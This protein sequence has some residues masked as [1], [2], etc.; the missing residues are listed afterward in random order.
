MA[1]LITGLDGPRTAQ[2]ELFHDLDDT[3]AIIG[4]SAAELKTIAGQPPTPDQALVLLKI[5]ALLLAQ[6][7]KLKSY[8]D[9]VSAGRIRRDAE[10][11]K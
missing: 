9:E 6:Q 5:C 10:Q 11:R 1:D 3:T 2:Q 8:A 4:W 7:E